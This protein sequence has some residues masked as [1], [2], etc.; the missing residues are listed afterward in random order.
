MFLYERAEKMLFVNVWSLPP[1]NGDKSIFNTIYPFDYR[2]ET[3]FQVNIVTPMIFSRYSYYKN[4]KNKYKGFKFNGNGTIKVKEF[5]GNGREGYI[6]TED[7]YFKG[8]FNGK[9]LLI[10]FVLPYTHEFQ[11]NQVKVVCLQNYLFAPEDPNQ[12]YSFVFSDKD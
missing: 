10:P 7:L 6:Q 4:W 3:C 8:L 2:G 5:Y 12:F 9:F 1:R 11:K